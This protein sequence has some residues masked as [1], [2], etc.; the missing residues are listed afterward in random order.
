MVKTLIRLLLLWL[1]AAMVFLYQFFSRPVS[2]AYRHPK[3][4]VIFLPGRFCQIP[5]PVDEILQKACCSVDLAAYNLDF[6]PLE[7]RL[8]EL[9]RRG[10]RLR[11]VTD[12][13]QRNRR[14]FERLKR[15]GIPVV[16]RPQGGLM[17][18]KFLVVDDRWVITGSANWTR[19]GLCEQANH[20]V[21]LDHPGVA[22]AYRK[23]FEEMFLH[24]RFG[25]RGQEA[26]IR[27]GDSLEI[28]FSPDMPV[29]D[30][31]VNRI[32]KVRD[33]LQVLALNLTDDRIAEALLRAR[34]RGVMVEVI[35]EENEP[36]GS[37][38]DRLSSSVRVC[39]DTRPALMH[40]KAMRMDGWL[41]FGS[42]N[43]SRSAATRNDEN[44]VLVR[45]NPE[46]IQMWNQAIGILKSTARC[47]G[48]SEG[49]SRMSSRFHFPGLSDLRRFFEQKG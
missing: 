42:Y 17:H 40:H 21:I 37:D 48:P 29:P 10:V 47:T 1:I 24:R 44:L 41:L 26:P 46:L 7:D 39:R 3:F 30:L 8:L 25:N 9:A 33:T 20:I 15:H 19:D 22:Q 27:F 28:W 4:S 35:A 31:I 12:G 32:Q 2:P 11:V 18:N 5:E 16:Y 36:Q 34:A 14:S 43:F 13:S 45:A 6:K 38:L 23:E 49:K